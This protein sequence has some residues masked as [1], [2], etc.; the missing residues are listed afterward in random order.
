MS[1]KYFRLNIDAMEG[2]VPGEQPQG[3]DFIKLNTNEN[4]Y[5]PSPKVLAALR[6]ECAQ[7]AR[8]YPDP[9]ANAVRRA[10]EKAYGLPL[11]QILVG[12]GSDDLLTII[13]RSYVDAGEA[14]AFPMPTYTLY[15][16]LAEIQ[17]ARA[18]EVDFPDD[19]VSFSP[20]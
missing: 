2:Y 12:N 3:G 17:G 19:D 10:A 7:T 8:L 15:R 14:V 5:P 4:P 13:M 1:S 20:R 6:A 11:D 16:T 9:M 18:I